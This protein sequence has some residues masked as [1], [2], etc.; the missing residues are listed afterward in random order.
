MAH[1]KL[2]F[3]V[4]FWT[5][6]STTFRPFSWKVVFLAIFAKNRV[7][8]S[9]GSQILGGFG[10]NKPIKT[11]VFDV[12]RVPKSGPK[13]GPKSVKSGHWQKPLT[14]LEEPVITAQTR[15]QEKPLNLALF[16]KIYKTTKFST[17]P[18]FLG[19][20][21]VCHFWPCFSGEFASLGQNDTNNRCFWPKNTDF[22]P[23][24]ALISPR[25]L[26]KMAKIAKIWP[27]CRKLSVF[28][29]WNRLIS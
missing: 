10:Q 27:F 19:F 7:I 25:T 26:A 12:F 9:E 11:S 14:M 15:N 29:C 1:Q 13:K 6:F 28:R 20:G 18:G 22:R 17:F 2:P 5:P 24:T 8:G 16:R 4:T 21:Q 3:L 23:K